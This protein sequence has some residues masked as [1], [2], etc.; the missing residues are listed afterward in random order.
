M[1]HPN[2]YELF[3]VPDAI[4]RLCRDGLLL[5]ESIPCELLMASLLYKVVTRLLPLD[6][7]RH[8]QHCKEK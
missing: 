6:T 7:D 2:K 1:C 4:T 3:M 8:E 5:T